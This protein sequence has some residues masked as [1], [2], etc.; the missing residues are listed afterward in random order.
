[1][2]GK[3]EGACNLKIETFKSVGALFGL[4]FEAGNLEELFD[5]L[6]SFFKSCTA[7]GEAILYYLLKQQWMFARSGGGRG[8]IDIREDSVAF[9]AFTAKQPFSETL[10]GEESPAEKNWAYPLLWKD[11][12]IGVLVLKDVKNLP[13]PLALAGFLR[14]A[15]VLID[16]LIR[17]SGRF[18][19][20]S[21]ELEQVFQ[22]NPDGIAVINRRRE[23]LKIN[24]SL[25]GLL[26]YERE[27]VSGKKCFEI[28][29]NCHCEKCKIFKQVEEFGR[30][31]LDIELKDRYGIPIPC[32]LSVSPLKNN[33]GEVIGIIQNVKDISDRKNS[34]AQVANSLKEK[35][36]LLKEIHHRVKN[37][38]QVIIALLELKKDISENHEVF[39]IL[40]ECVQ[41][42]RSMALVHEE[43][44]KSD[45]FRKIRFDQYSRILIR[46]ILEEYAKE[47]E[48]KLIMD[49]DE[50]IVFNINYMI[51]LGLILNELTTNTI[52]HGLAGKKSGEIVLSVKRHGAWYKLIYRDNG[53]GIP[54]DMDFR[55][56][57][58]LGM[59]LI[60]NLTHQIG[61]SLELNRN[62]GAEFIFSFRYAG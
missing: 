3:T 46:L 21:V 44:Y 25:L 52:K 41:R 61:G 16:S 54:A 32:I 5:R 57:T 47:D 40:T 62:R 17:D 45:D 38:L 13:D 29:N 35:E 60:F 4:F 48:L 27:E 7:C 55:K 59:Q 19:A 15:A 9:G 37:N 10:K 14:F 33:M 26:K 18:E 1:M 20:S 30:Q 51:P 8:V 22:S 56:I 39:C 53:K 6:F 50:S 58:T 2:K 31:E 11:Q 42:I 23:I 28:F 43:M 36:I 12:L 24:D 34:E 49:I